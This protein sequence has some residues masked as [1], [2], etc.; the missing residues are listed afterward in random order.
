MTDMHIKMPD[1]IPLVRY[2][3]NGTDTVY[4]Y[5]FPVFASEDI[6]VLIDGVKLNHG[7]AVTQA[8]DT[9][10]GEILFDTAPISGA[11]VT[12]ERRVPYERLS[13]FLES[14]EFSA[15]S[16][17]NELDYLMASVQQLSRDQQSM[18]RYTPAENAAD[19]TMP[20][21]NIRAGKVLGFDANGN[22]IAVDYGLTQAAPSFTATGT[23]AVNRHI[24]DKAAEHISVRDFGAVGDGVVDDTLAFRKALNAHDAVY[25]PTGIYRITDTIDIESRKKLYGGGTSSIIKADSDLFIAVYIRGEFSTL[26]DFVIEN[27]EAGL[28]LCGQSTQCVQNNIQNLVIRNAAKGIVLDGGA[29]VNRPCYWNKFSNVLVQS[30]SYIGIH[31]TK[32]GAGDTP[33]ANTF[34]TCRVYS[35]GASISGHGIYVQ[36]G[37]FYNRFV[38]CEVNVS[39]TAQSCVM[40]GAGADENILQNLY[41]ETDGVVAN[42]LLAS[43]SKNTYI[44]NLLA[45]SAGAAIDDQSGG[46]YEA[47]NAGYPIKHKINSVQAND[48]TSVLHRQDTLYID[49]P[50]EAV[51]D[52]VTD[53][54]VQLIGATNGPIT[55]RLPDPLPHNEATYTIKKIDYTN[56]PVRITGTTGAGPDGKDLVLGGRYDYATIISNGAAW[57]ILASNRMAGT[58][59]YH[60][61]TGLFDI[62]M[63]V[64]TYLVSSYNGALTCRLPPADAVQAINR[65]ITIK[66][67]DPS[68]NTVT[69]VEQGGAGADQESQ[70]LT[71][72]YQAITLVSDGNQWF[73][74]SRYK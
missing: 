35:H 27:G 29:D 18:L 32:T 50:G 14:G 5:P 51:M 59:Q 68:V 31:L 11:T 57:F 70:I 63:T 36:H 16:L 22:P 47:M 2:T 48:L 28:Y 19:T 52:L 45:M 10:G 42:V 71:E 62:D 8:G 23:G 24:T 60:D 55:I 49:A 69:I 67:T 58:T 74:L 30:P 73:V 17:N 13:D 25:I 4:A 53:I 44:H 72:R 56:N 6:T 12:I 26:S 7:Y 38:D 1:V 34:D 41:T 54:S 46:A 39:T 64:D 3:A 20:D 9:E 66:K 15:R 65:T 61:G 40:M 37:R 33:N 43:G 21:R